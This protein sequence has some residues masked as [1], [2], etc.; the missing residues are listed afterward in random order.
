MPRL[1]TR[2][3]PTVCPRCRALILVALDSPVAGIPVRLDPVP[4][5]A[6]QELAARLAGRATYDL[7][8][9][10][11]VEVA[12]R[13][14]YAITRRDWPVLATHTCPGP[15]PGDL[16]NTPAPDPDPDPVDVPPY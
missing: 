9:R 12:Y 15:V 2:P 16:L 1:S 11:R 10:A 5:D 7:T 13:D 4:L 3:H 8:G 6:E 14:E